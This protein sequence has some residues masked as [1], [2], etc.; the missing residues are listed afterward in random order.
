MLQ[1][2]TEK[3][4]WALGL[5]M[6]VDIPL[7]WWGFS[8]VFLGAIG[9][10]LFCG[11]V[12]RRIHQVSGFAH[13]G[14]VGEIVERLGT[15]GDDSALDEFRF[16]KSEAQ[17]RV[18]VKIGEDFLQQVRD[19][20]RY[21]AWSIGSHPSVQSRGGDSECFGDL[22]PRQAVRFDF[23]DDQ[24][25]CHRGVTYRFFGKNRVLFLVDRKTD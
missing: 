21:W 1:L 13:D 3:A 6:I 11:Q 15:A 20:F 4:A 25:T 18:A 14:L 8:G 19:R 12:L 2:L 23:L 24:L 16:G 17:F 9:S 7:D 10:F 22:L 5:R